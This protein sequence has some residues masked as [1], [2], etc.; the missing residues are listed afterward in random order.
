MVK[1]E[2]QIM[3][4][5]LKALFLVLGFL[6]PAYAGT[7]NNIVTP[8][9]WINPPIWGGPIRIWEGPITASS[10]IPSPATPIWSYAITNA[11]SV[12]GTNAAIWSE[13][14]F[15][16]DTSGNA[17]VLLNLFDS[18]TN[19]IGYNILWISS[20]GQLLETLS[21][22]STNTP[23]VIL[24]VSHSSLYLTGSELTNS[25]GASYAATQYTLRGKQLFITPIGTDADGLLTSGEFKPS[26]SSFGF[27]GRSISGTT[28][29]LNCYLYGNQ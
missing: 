19:Y 22:A 4:T 5:S 9:T 7:N 14:Q 25:T 2:N 28:N 17:A 18:S 13:G 12:G 3:K 11:P 6:V 20:R 27:I 24:S 8:I 10:N 1:T 23:P 21:Q 15:A 29:S 16:L 26:L